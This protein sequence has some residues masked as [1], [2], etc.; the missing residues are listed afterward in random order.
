[1]QSPTGGADTIPVRGDWVRIYHSADP[2]GLHPFNGKNAFATFIKENIYM[3]LADFNSQTLL[4]EPSLMNGEPEISADGLS[5]TYEM[6]PE[7][8]WDNGDPI[9]G[10]DYAFSIKCAKN[11]LTDNA[12]SRTYHSFILDVKVDPTNPRRF[13]VS[14]DEPFF[15][16]QIALEG[17]EVISHQFYDSSNVLGKYSVADFKAREA[18]IVDDPAVKAFSENFNSDKYNRDPAFIYGSGPYKLESWTPGENVTLVRKKDWWGDQLRGKGSYFQAYPEKLI[19]KTIRDRE[20]VPAA[21][22]NGELD[23]VRDMSPDDYLAAREDTAGYIYKNFNFHTPPSYGFQFLGFNCRPPANRQPILED[24][25]VRKAFAYI[26]QID[27]IIQNVYSGF[28]KRQIG[29]I[30]PINKD[31][32]HAALKGYEFNPEKAKQLLDEAGWVDAD[33]NGVREKMIKGKKVELRLEILLSNG[34]ETG[35]RMVRVIIDQAQKVGMVLELNRID[36]S[37]LQQRIRDHDFDIFGL[38]FSASP[39]PTDLKQLW[40]TENWANNGTNYF[41]F[42][43]ATTDSLINQIRAT[44]L[45][46][47][48]TPLY[49]KFQELWIDELPA[50]VIMSPTERIWIHK[51]F[52][53]ANPTTLRPG[54]KAYE[55]WVPL[56]DQK[57]K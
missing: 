53:N 8:R 45:A 26:T 15:L 40:A 34:G 13:T 6:R 36:F 44:P 39:L 18:E 38:G 10:E 37:V 51:R 14:T 30:S 4:S 5:F 32:Y 22:Q 1:M 11:P 43:N 42:G 29:P 23:V 55:F 24:A 49:H 21:T 48:R 57:F 3:Y 54:Y 35:P 20:T 52:H 47:D 9:T 28:G 27:S 33:G 50:L 31:E 46:A 12:Q 2:D 25:R 41:G 19:Y 16:T 7:A 17:I 56:A